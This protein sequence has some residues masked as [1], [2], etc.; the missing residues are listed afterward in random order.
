MRAVFLGSPAAAVPSLAALAEIADIALVVTNP[1]RRSGRGSATLATA[2]K[3]AADEWGIAVAQ[4]DDD[5]SLRTAVAA[6]ESD[7]A[8]VVA[9][10]RI[11]RKETLATTRVGFVN[12]HFS[13]LPRW[14]GA[15]PVEHAILY[16]DEETGVSL[17]R[18]DE[19]LDTG[20]VIAIRKA[21]IVPSDTGGSLTARLSAL[22][23]SLLVDALP[24]FMTGALVP[25]AQIDAGTT[26]APR[27]TPFDA[28]LDPQ[29][30]ATELERAIRA[31]HPRPGAWLSV[32]DTR[33]KV[34]GAGSAEAIL[35]P[36]RIEL[37]G[38][39]VLLGTGEGALRLDSVQ[40]AGKGVQR[41][42]SWMH[43]RRGEP[44]TAGAVEQ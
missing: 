25:A 42:R 8:V 7:I 41:A 21:E 28:Q 12:V 13:V 19:G 40:P 39:E 18:L 1:D 35:P 3:R 38:D 27:L 32:D 30:S 22:G 44:A 23:A 36:G 34:L 5:E 43:G 17:M 9:Y 15:S 6:T 10:G 4:P 24:S 29:R 26:Y 16:G 33:L 2:V 31:F 14:R 20:P 11:L 37:V